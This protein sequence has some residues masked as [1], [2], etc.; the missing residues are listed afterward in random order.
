MI[1]VYGCSACGVMRIASMKKTLYCPKC[2]EE[3]KRLALTF[4]EFSEMTEDERKS[5][6]LKNMYKEANNCLH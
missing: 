5:H 6:I 1:K 4:L 3:M 2:R